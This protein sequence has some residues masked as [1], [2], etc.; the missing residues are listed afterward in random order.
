M[1]GRATVAV[2]AV[3]VLA[4]G[5]VAYIP[6]IF[7]GRREQYSRKEFTRRHPEFT[8]L[9]WDLFLELAWF[10]VLMLC[11]ATGHRIGGATRRLI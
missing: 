4:S 3:L 10:V 7:V 6:R 11:N 9:Q 1:Q 8:W 2:I 5:I